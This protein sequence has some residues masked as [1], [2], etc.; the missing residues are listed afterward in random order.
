ML[1]LD[2][3]RVRD[4]QLAELLLI[5]REPEEVIL[6]V[7]LLWNGLVNRAAVVDQLVGPV[8]P[9]AADTVLPL[10]VPLVDV[11]RG[12]AGVPQLLGA[13]N[14]ERVGAR[15]EE[16]VVG[17]RQRLAKRAEAF[18]VTLHQ[19]G[20]GIQLDRDIVGPGVEA[21][22][23]AE[24]AVMTGERVALHRFERMTNMGIPIDIRD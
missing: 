22:G 5:L 19:F 4:D 2:E 17:Q 20:Q 12:G 11:A 21:G 1:R 10:V 16:D 24:Q 8:E 18:R 6:L 23:V 14:V 15:P 3:Q 13:G 9:L 7:D